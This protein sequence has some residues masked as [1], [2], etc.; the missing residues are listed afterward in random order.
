MSIIM[1]QTMPA[2]RQVIAF[3][4]FIAPVRQPTTPS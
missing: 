4:G 1:P 3:F 2:S